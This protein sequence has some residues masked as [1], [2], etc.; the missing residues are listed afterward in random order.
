MVI[1]TSA[2]VAYALNEPTRARLLVAIRRAP[3]PCMSA[4]ALVEL[5]M[6]LIGRK[7]ERATAEVD[8]LLNDLGIE[9]VAVT[10][11]TA[12]LAR[13]AFARFGKSRHPAALNFGDCFS[14]A[15]AAE[16]SEPLLFVGD[17]FARTTIEAAPY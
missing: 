16:R 17:D 7:G 6:V 11:Q 4:V 9:I 12:E 5:S 15:L 8:A 2:L 14:Y 1:D 10:R 3:R 13:T